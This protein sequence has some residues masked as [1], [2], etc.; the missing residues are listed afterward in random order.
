M[1]HAAH[2][3]T[4]HAIGRTAYSFCYALPANDRCKASLLSPPHAKKTEPVGSAFSLCGAVTRHLT[5]EACCACRGVHAIEYLSLL[6]GFQSTTS[7]F[8]K[9]TE[10]ERL[11]ERTR[12]SLFAFRKTICLSF[13]SKSSKAPPTAKE[14]TLPLGMTLSSA[15]SMV[16]VPL[17]QVTSVSLMRRES[18]DCRRFENIRADERRKSLAERSAT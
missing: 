2:A 12:T 4:M 9:T 5:C 15:G 17:S 14:C 3:V 10:G 8:C 7:A 13:H 11:S 1:K 6:R 16:S 18:R